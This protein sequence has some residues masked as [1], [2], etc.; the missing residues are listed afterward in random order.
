MTSERGYWEAPEKK[1]PFSA[2]EGLYHDASITSENMEALAQLCR[3]TQENDIRL[4]IR[5]PP[6]PGPAPEKVKVPVA[7]MKELMELQERFKKVAV[8]TPVVLYEDHAFFSDSDHCN[9]QGA[10]R[11]TARVAEEVQRMMK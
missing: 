3:L 10:E 6:V 8:S 4:L 9:R 1:G 5:L 11:F 2:P 7:W